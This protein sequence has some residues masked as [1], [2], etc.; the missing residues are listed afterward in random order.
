[1]F[2]NCA[3]GALVSFEAA[4]RVVIVYHFRVHEPLPSALTPVTLDT[5]QIVFDG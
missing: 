1:M 2:W 4:M 5:N 3:F